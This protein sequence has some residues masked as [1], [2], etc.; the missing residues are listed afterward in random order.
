MVPPE[1]VFRPA[2][3]NDA[4][5]VARLHAD[6]WRRHYRG[7]YAD[8]YLD[9]DIE[10]ERLQV[11]TTRLADAARADATTATI[12]AEDHQGLLGFVHVVFDD[13]QQWGALVANLHVTFDR[14]RGGIGTELMSRAAAALLEREPEGRL[15]LWVLEQNTAA[16]A[17]YSAR[18]GRSVEREEAPPPGG[19]A[20]RL[21]GP[22]VRLRYAWSDPREL[23]V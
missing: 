11:W 12:L 7:A 13:D 8:A 17:F 3:A 23:I 22:V 14:K 16:Q 2:E 21:N 18:G 20:S 4:A 1:V 15:Y 5:S 19:D 10:S 9:G 6:S